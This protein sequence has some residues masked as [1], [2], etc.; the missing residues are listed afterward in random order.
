MPFDVDQSV[1]MQGWS[2][3]G[4]LKW[5]E[6]LSLFLS[7]WPSICLSCAELR[8][9]SEAITRE[10]HSDSITDK[11][12]E[13]YPRCCAFSTVRATVETVADDWTVPNWRTYLTV[14]AFLCDAL[15]SDGRHYYDWTRAKKDRRACSSFSAVFDW[16][17]RIPRSWKNHL[18][19]VVLI[20]YLKWFVR[21]A[22]NC[23]FC[24]VSSIT[25][26]NRRARAYRYRKLCLS[27][28]VMIRIGPLQI[29]QD[30][31]E[32]NSISNKLS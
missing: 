11:L 25:I 12:R 20:V 9:Q 24:S 8:I 22:T 26:W 3:F 13:W 7:D 30:C 27:M 6:K 19:E 2:F 31:I 29:K 15:P 1:D 23:W 21:S 18:F 10:S 5:F 32:G 16:L 14:A 17:R 28:D 4:L